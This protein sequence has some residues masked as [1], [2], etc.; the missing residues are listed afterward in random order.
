VTVLPEAVVE[1][2]RAQIESARRIHDRDLAVGNG[3]VYLPGALERKYPGANREWG[4]Q[5]VF[6]AELLSVDPRSG[7]VRRHHVEERG[8]QTAVHRALKEAGIHKA[9]SCH[10]LRHGFATALLES[11][12]DIRTVQELMGHT[13]VSTTQIY[14]HVLNRP[15][16]GVRSPLDG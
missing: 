6:P 13:D 9:A 4:W 15:G 8:L 16:M 12:C 3:E 10:S 14:T 11:G 5:Y 1:R 2:L 7:K